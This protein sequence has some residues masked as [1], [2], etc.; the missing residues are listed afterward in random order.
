MPD[1]RTA[2]TLVGLLSLST[3]AAAQ[4][5]DSTA[6]RV[7]AV[8]A[9]PDDELVVA[10]ALAALARQG[11]EVTLLYATRGDAGP[12]VSSLARGGALAARREQ[13]ARCAA[14]ALGAK[15]LFMDEIGDGTLGQRAHDPVSPAALFLEQLSRAYLAV[16][17]GLVI[18]WGPDGGYGHADHRMVSALVSEAV[19]SLSGADRPGLLYA[20]IRA[21]TL[22]PVAELQE[23]A[24]TDPALLTQQ[25]AYTAED[26]AAARAATQC[27]ATQFGPEVRAALADLFDQS[28]WRGAV[29]FRP[30]F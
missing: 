20:A 3:A 12:G 15:A 28:I 1:F 27:H 19:Q 18:T 4:P 2:L 30:A 8:F 17:P 29:H 21:G 11:S 22:P 13:E 10:P 25:I 7:L 6:P 14:T 23:W 5:A 26:L 9:H 24:V 16:R